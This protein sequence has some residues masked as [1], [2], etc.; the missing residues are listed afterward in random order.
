MQLMSCCHSEVTKA[1]LGWWEL[2][3]IRRSWR[4]VVRRVSRRLEKM[5]AVFLLESFIVDQ[6][7]TV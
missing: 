3:N 5:S 2:R 6:A 4:K 1:G 7:D